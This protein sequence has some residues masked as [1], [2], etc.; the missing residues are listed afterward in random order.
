[1]RLIV[2]LGN[3]GTKYQHN[4]HNIGFMAMDEIIHRHNLSGPQK[5]F[6][7]LVYEGTIAGEKLLVMKP[8]TFMNLSGEAVQ[9]AMAF[10]KIAPENIIVFYDELDLAA[11]KIRV[12]F[13][14]GAAGHNGI[15]S[16]DEHVGQDYWR[17]RLGIGHP[18]DKERVTGHVLGDFSKD[19]QAWLE[20][21]LPALAE[22]IGLIIAGDTNGYMSKVAQVLEPPR[23]QEKKE[24]KDGI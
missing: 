22:H 16:I 21:F 20:K 18:G 9:A 17:V 2:G 4:R 11:G 14:G 5:K 13:A 1:M 19:D 10:Y 3:P 6:K 23:N 24:V 15:R 12:K 7:A 8:E